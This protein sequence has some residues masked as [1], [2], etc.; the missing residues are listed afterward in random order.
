MPGSACSM[1]CPQVTLRTLLLTDTDSA[2]GLKVFFSFAGDTSDLPNQ[3]RV[4]TLEAFSS[5]GVSGKQLVLQ[6]SISEGMTPCWVDNTEVTV[7][8][9]TQTQR[10]TANSCMY[11][12][13]RFLLMHNRSTVY[14]TGRS[15]VHLLL[16]LKGLYCGFG[17]KW[18]QR[19]WEKQ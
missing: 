11:W 3:L 17:P 1:Y 16:Q 5:R 6:F 2:I 12:I 18:I 7:A 10:E 8:M 15:Q 14:L 9:K 4:V 19:T 13:T